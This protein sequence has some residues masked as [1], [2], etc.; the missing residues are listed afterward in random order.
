MKSVGKEEHR[1]QKD[2][3]DAIN[4]EQRL[5]AVLKA[6]DERVN[7]A[8]QQI[9]GHIKELNAIRSNPKSIRMDLRNAK[10]RTYHAISAQ[11]DLLLEGHAMFRNSFEEQQSHELEVRLQA[12]GKHLQTIQ[13][14]LHDGIYSKEEETILLNLAQAMQREI[15]FDRGI[16]GLIARRTTEWEQLTRIKG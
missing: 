14:H 16:K 15:V 11:I 2:L 7:D 5:I 13:D 8:I 3:G 4:D 12:I 1:V 6:L 9:D 10:T